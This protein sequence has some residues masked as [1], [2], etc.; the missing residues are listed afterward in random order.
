M[1]STLF[2]YAIP[3]STILLGIYLSFFT[4]ILRDARIRQSGD[5]SK[6]PYSFARTQLMWWTL[7]ILPC[8]CAFYGINLELLNLKDTSYLVLLGISLGTV[9]SARIIDNTDMSNQMVRHQDINDSKGFL[10]DIISDENGISIHR[11][12][13]LAFNFIFGVIFIAKFISK[14]EFVAFNEFEL[15]LMGISSAA[16]VGMKISENGKGKSGVQDLAEGKLNG[17][18][19]LDSAGEDD[20]IDIDE[21]YNNNVNQ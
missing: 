1:I 9:T 8:F 15:G 2:I 12:Q 14:N 16:Y 20:L 19:A 17:Q 6:I 11:F 10:I 4:E 13:A 21:S 5:F 18:T 3:I 7:I